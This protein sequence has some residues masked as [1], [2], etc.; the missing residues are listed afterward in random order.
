MV[1]VKNPNDYTL[2]KF[3][4]SKTKN[5]KYDAIIK[6][7]ITKKLKTIPFGDVRYEHY[8]DSTG[9]GEYSH[10]NHFDKKRRKNYRLRH[11]KT[12]KNKFSSSWFSYYYLW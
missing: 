9:L 1:V 2:V 3:K 12:A 11:N 5:K 6:H 10:L 8:Q 7:R 4:K